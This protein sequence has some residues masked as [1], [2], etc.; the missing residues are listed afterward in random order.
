MAATVNRYK[1]EKRMGKHTE[2]EEKVAEFRKALES[3]QYGLLDILDAGISEETEGELID[4]LEITDDALG[5][6]LFTD[7]DA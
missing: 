5:T 1:E 3:I 4:L 7:V 6:S 2:V